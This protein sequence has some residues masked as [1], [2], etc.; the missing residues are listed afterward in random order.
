MKTRLFFKQ[1]WQLLSALLL[2]L[3]LALT[4]AACD[5]SQDNWQPPKAKKR[6]AKRKSKLKKL[7]RQ[8]RLT[9]LTLVMSRSINAIPFARI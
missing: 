4:G 9:R 5:D 3:T 1:H 2:G 6:R 8:R 7:R